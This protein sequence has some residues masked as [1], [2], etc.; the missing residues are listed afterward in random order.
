LIHFILQ[1]FRRSS[2]IFITLF[3][4]LCT[5][6]PL[7]V[8]GHGDLHERIAAVTL[9]IKQH[10]DSAYLYMKRGELQYQD[11]SYKKALKD[12]RKSRKLG[13][14]SPRLQHDIAATEHKLGR[15]KIALAMI[16]ALLTEDPT[17]AQTH[18]FRGQVLYDMEQYASAAVAFEAAIDFAVTTIPEN[19]LEASDAWEKSQISNRGARAIAIIEKGISVLGPLTVFFNRLIEHSINSS[20]YKQA[21]FYHSEVISRSTRKEWAYF[22]RAQTYRMMG[23][24]AH[25]REDLLAS[26]HAIAQLPAR[27]QN[28]QSIL[29]LKQRIND[30]LKPMHE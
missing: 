11:N 13:Y 22:E 30:Q 10:R 15:P 14:L 24:T 2:G 5:T 4:A 25:E 17:H 7:R 21:I 6:L 9:E 19:Y 18:R 8:S 26:K 29:K 16:D 27:L 28:Q 23:D 1:G 20:D 3:F 12:F